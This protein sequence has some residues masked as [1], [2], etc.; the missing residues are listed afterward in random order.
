MH[1]I[2]HR[3]KELKHENEELKILLSLTGKTCQEYETKVDI[4]FPFNNPI[5]YV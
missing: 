3:L 2:H 1:D 5:E 4:F